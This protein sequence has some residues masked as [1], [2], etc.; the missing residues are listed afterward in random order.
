MAVVISQ[1]ATFKDDNWLKKTFIEKKEPIDT[2]SKSAQAYTCLSNKQMISSS[3]TKVFSRLLFS[4]CPFS[5]IFMM[6]ISNSR[7]K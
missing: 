3:L 5:E 7:D 6:Q 4:V 1:T 2:V